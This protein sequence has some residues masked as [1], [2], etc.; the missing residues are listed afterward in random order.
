MKIPEELRLE[1]TISMM[2][3]LLLMT[4]EEALFFNYVKF[5]GKDL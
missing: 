3:L 5:I 1:D 4:F 2:F